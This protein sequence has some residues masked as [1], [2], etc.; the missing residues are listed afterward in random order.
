M[1]SHAAVATHEEHSIDVSLITVELILAKARVIS[2]LWHKSKIHVKNQFVHLR[3]KIK[4]MGS[5][6]V[7]L[8]TFPLMYRINHYCR[9]DIV[10]ARV[11]SAL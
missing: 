6:A 8:K 5:H 10:K 4:F 11:I 9:T 1:G 7:I 2:A 3:R